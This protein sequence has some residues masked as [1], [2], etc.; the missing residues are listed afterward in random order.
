MS[1]DAYRLMM[2][3]DVYMEISVFTS[4][5]KNL[6]LPIF[7]NYT[8]HILPDLSATTC[9]PP[10]CSIEKS[11]ATNST[12]KELLDD[13]GLQ[14]ATTCLSPALCKSGVSHIER[15]KKAARQTRSHTIGFE[16]CSESWS[17]STLLLE[18][19]RCRGATRLL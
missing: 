10:T 11:I 7:P 17:I 3:S 12:Y 5:N 13:T 4:Y 15:E 2:P 1:A 9:N 6:L 14:L 19:Y 16:R 8:I 18:T